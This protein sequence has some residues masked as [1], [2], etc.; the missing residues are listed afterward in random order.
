MENSYQCTNCPDKAPY[1]NFKAYQRHVHLKHPEEGKISAEDLPEANKIKCLLPSKKTPG[2]LCNH[3]VKKNDISR[4]VIGHGKS[5]PG[6]KIFKGFFSTDGKVSYYP[7]WGSKNE[8]F[9]EE[10]IIEIDVVTENVDTKNEEEAEHADDG[11]GI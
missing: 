1:T 7:A 9:A 2:R 6:T 10:E 11:G 5:R 8:V 3:P 4:H